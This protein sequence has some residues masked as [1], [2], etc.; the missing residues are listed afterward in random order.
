MDDDTGYY[1]RAEMDLMADRHHTEAELAT[2]A[3]L[4]GD[5]DVLDALA[6]IYDDT[7]DVRSLL[8]AVAA[9]KPQQIAVEARQHRAS[10]CRIDIAQEP[11]AVLG[12]RRGH[13]RVARLRP[14]VTE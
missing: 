7:E 14:R 3:D 6:R 13:E 10:G 12:C 11:R 4:Y 5:G 1:S 2:L 9:T 8:P